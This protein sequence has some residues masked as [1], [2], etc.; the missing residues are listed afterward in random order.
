MLRRRDSQ[1]RISGLMSMECIPLTLIQRFVFENCCG[2]GILRYLRSLR[3]T[4]DGLVSQ[5]AVHWRSR[6]PDDMHRPSSCD[7]RSILALLPPPQ[8]TVVHLTLH[9]PPF[10]SQR[11]PRCGGTHWIVKKC[12]GKAIP[13]LMSAGN[14]L[15]GLYPPAYGGRKMRT[16]PGYPR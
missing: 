15:G 6:I 2:A 13:G 5:D 9:C 14:K 10:Q 11:S 8:Q 3:M 7:E 4:A 16:T 12:Q 1:R